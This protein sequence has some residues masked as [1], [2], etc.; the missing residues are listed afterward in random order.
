M[1]LIKVQ[2]SQFIIPIPFR[3]ACSCLTMSTKKNIQHTNRVS[4]GAQWKSHG[5]YL[6]LFSRP[7]EASHD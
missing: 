3:I 4:D 2:A 6:I 1:Y 7:D 5:K